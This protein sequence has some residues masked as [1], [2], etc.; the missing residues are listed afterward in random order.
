M[1]PSRFKSTFAST[2]EHVEPGLGAGVQEGVIAFE[3]VHQRIDPRPLGR[4]LAVEV[5]RERDVAKL[6]RQHVRA[7][8]RVVAEPVALVHDDD[9]RRGRAVRAVGQIA[10]QGEAPAVVVD[11]A[12]PHRA[13]ASVG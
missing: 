9:A 13:P 11:L 7:L 3:L 2:F 1:A 4:P 5:D 12:R 6:R 8:A 10:V